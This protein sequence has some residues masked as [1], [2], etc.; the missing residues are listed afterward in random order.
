MRHIFFIFLIAALLAACNRAESGYTI[1][2]TVGS[3]FKD[4][5]I[6]IVD[7]QEQQVAV[8]PI[9]DGK[10]VLKGRVDEPQLA[11]VAPMT[12]GV[13]A[14]MI[15]ENAGYT[16]HGE[17]ERA[18]LKGGGP[19]NRMVYEFESTDEFYNNMIAYAEAEDRI[20][21]D[22]KTE[23]DLSPEE[24][25]ELTEKADAILGLEDRIMFGVLDDPDA[26]PLAKVFAIER[27]QNWDEYPYER[28]IP[29]LKRLNEELGGNNKTAMQLW[30]RYER[31]IVE[32]AAEEAEKEA[33]A[34][35][36]PF[37]EIEARDAEGRMVK[38]S[39][40]MARNKYVLIDFW[41]S[42]CRP[43][44]KEIPNLKAAYDKYKAKGL[45]IFAVSIDEKDQDWLGALKKE[46]TPWINVI[47]GGNDANRY[48]VEAVPSGFLIS[49]EGKIVV[50]D[51]G[52]RGRKLS[53]TLG[54]Y[55]P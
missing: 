23:E 9:V 44:L 15:L 29:L 24:I 27:S 33:V 25:S 3:T 43:C 52:L 1:R 40:V 37:K 21:S 16:F 19:L 10:F 38:L 36:M 2:G 54:R 18:I 42:W 46:Q 12:E 4:D 55:M 26:P 30:E 34:A 35:G 20:F 6:Q 17:Y 45:E 41:A 11:F 5:S 47:D 28:R 32:I 7:E 53:E 39:E 50:A 14:R 31:D 13:M 8:A 51:E 48:G 49:R 22:G